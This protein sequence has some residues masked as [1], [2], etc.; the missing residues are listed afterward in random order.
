MTVSHSSSASSIEAR[1]LADWLKHLGVLHPKNIE[2]GLDRVAQ[3]YQRLKL[4]FSANTVV[5]VAGTN[6]KGTTCVMLEQASLVA[7]KTVA[8]YSSPHLLDYRERVRVNGAML[9][10]SAH[11]QAFATVEVARGDIALTYFEF[12]T[13]AALQLMHEAKVDIL[14]LEVGLG[15]RLD[16]VNVV[17]PDIALITSID[18]DHQDWLGDTIEQIAREKAGIFR[19]NGVAV[20]GE[21]RPMQALTDA[22]NDLHVRATWQGR[23]FHFSQTDNEFNWSN[24]DLELTNLPLPQIPLQNA[25]SALQVI[26]LLK[27]NLDQQQLEHVLAHSHLPGRQQLLQCAPDV[28]LDVA[29]NPHATGHLVSQIDRTRYQQI[30]LVVGMLIDKDIASSLAPFYSLDANWFVGTLD[31]PRGANS[32][33]LKSVLRGQQKVLEFATISQAYLNA[34]ASAGKDDLVVVF[35]S[36][37][38][39]AEVI[40]LNQTL[41]IK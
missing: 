1:S 2:L 26:Q 21:P 33:E 4:D 32:N 16:A 13:L 39:V 7:G 17:D 6:G 12:G 25:S 29:H 22:V 20:I 41:R 31:V 15:G 30:Y 34:L 23:D 37:F 10:E 18:L 27:F 14:L 19:A 35:G 5:T 24:G 38:T 3:V 40:K 11:C 9:D 36:F 28:L 8:V